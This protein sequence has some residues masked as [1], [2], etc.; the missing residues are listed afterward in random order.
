MGSRPRKENLAYIA[1]FLDGDGSLMLQVKKRKDGK[2]GWRFMSTIS[3][4]Q[5]S[6]HSQPLIWIRKQLG[7]GY[8]SNRK[9]GISELRI[10]GFAQTERI[11]E[12]LLPYIRFKKV[13]AKMMLKAAKILS[14]RKNDLLSEK[15]AKTIAR[16][17][18]VIR[19]E[20]YQSGKKRNQSISEIL[21]LTPYRLNPKG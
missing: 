14:K 7:I 10:N 2:M 4:Y 8:L 18:L 19:T 11:I 6:R 13:Q 17:I 1:G 3:F 12:Q 15:D 20:N 9:D 16:A 5:D 21:G